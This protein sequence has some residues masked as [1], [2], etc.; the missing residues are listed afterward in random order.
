MRVGGTAQQPRRG[1]GRRQVVARERRG[2]LE[3]QRAP[4]RGRRRA[5]QLRGGEVGARRYVARPGPH[6]SRAAPR[7]AARRRRV[8]SSSTSLVPPRKNGNP[9]SRFWL[10]RSHATAR[11]ALLRSP[12][13]SR[14]RAPSA[15][16][17]VSC[18][19]NRVRLPGRQGVVSRGPVRLEPAVGALLRL[20]PG[21]GGRRGGA[22][23]RAPAEDREPDPVDAVVGGV[24]HPDEPAVA[25]GRGGSCVHGQQ[26]GDRG[27]AGD[28]ADGEPTG[29]GG[30][31]RT[32]TGRR[33]SGIG[34]AMLPVTGGGRA[35]GD[36]LPVQRSATW[37]G[38]PRPV[39]FP[40][41]RTP[42][43]TGVRGGVCSGLRPGL[44]SVDLDGR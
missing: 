23:G 38:P 33:P 19:V 7:T 21:H 14:A 25:G 18:P 10:A 30:P 16:L 4:R 2:H 28:H 42:G 22:P 1:L 31:V 12:T 15:V 26:Q 43:T 34:G 17:L 24:L 32:S 9:P 5:A 20:E 8:P 41:R 35:H 13:A 11:A 29:R 44:R 40:A 39:G 36:P 37:S 3:R 27:G 6:R